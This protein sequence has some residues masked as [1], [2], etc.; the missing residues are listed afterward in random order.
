MGVIQFWYCFFCLF[1]FW[2]DWFE[3]MWNKLIQHLH[4]LQSWFQSGR[5]NPIV[6]N[7]SW[8]EDMIS[9]WLVLNRTFILLSVCVF[10]FLF[11]W[12]W[13]RY[14]VNVGSHVDVIVMNIFSSVFF[15]F[16][17]I[18]LVSVRCLCFITW[19]VSSTHQGKEIC[20]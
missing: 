9:P 12:S 6:I 20:T 1:F 13:C 10:N 15:F 4:D 18:I 3:I 2:F 17:I 8:F 11:T 19:C 16:I 5:I 14:E 7:N